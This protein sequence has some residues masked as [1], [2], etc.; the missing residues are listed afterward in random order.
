MVIQCR[1][2]RCCEHAWTCIFVV[3]SHELGWPSFVPE[4]EVNRSILNNWAEEAEEAVSQT[5]LE[6]LE[7]GPNET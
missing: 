3:S 6:R 2:S 1:A 5:C 4:A 7:R